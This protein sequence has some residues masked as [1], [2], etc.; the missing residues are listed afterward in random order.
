MHLPQVGLNWIWPL[1]K[2]L[3]SVYCDDKILHA[4]IAFFGGHRLESLGEVADDVSYAERGAP[5]IVDNRKGIKQ[6]KKKGKRTTRS[7]TL[8]NAVVYFLSR[9]SS[10]IRKEVSLEVCASTL[11]LSKTPIRLVESRIY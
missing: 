6:K 10:L 1:V 4:Y 2:W 5:T 3:Q 8:V 11:R 7:I 9:T